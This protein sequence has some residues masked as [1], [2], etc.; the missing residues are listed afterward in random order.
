MGEAKTVRCK[1][2]CVSIERRK[3]WTGT[4]T[5]ELHDAKFQVVCDVSE[6]S[7][8]FFSST[9]GGEIRVSALLPD[10]FVLG[11]RYYVDFT[12]AGV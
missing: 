1:F 11:G 5:E 12:P 8:A 6:E 2:E 10:L 7:R 3:G 4:K 9:P